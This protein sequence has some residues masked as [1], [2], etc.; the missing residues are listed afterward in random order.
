MLSRCIKLP[1]KYLF[2]KLFFRLS[3]TL[4]LFIF[5][6]IFY[7]KNLLTSILLALTSWLFSLKKTS[8]HFYKN[9]LDF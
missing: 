2:W 6:V 9:M 1:N 4:E 5:Q 7:F 8:H 3:L